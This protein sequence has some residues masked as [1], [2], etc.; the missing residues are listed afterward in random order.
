MHCIEFYDAS[1][2]DSLQW[3]Q[4]PDGL[5]AQKMLTPM[6]KR[7]SRIF[8]SNAQAQVYVLKIHDHILPITVN[9]KE[10]DNSY[11]ASNY[12]VIPFIKEWLVQKPNLKWVGKPVLWAFGKC[13]RVLKVNK[14]VFINN[15]LLSSNLYPQ[16]SP[17]FLQEVKQFLTQ[18]FPDHVLMFRN[19]NVFKEMSLMHALQKEK[20]HIMLT[21]S[22][23]VYD[24]KKKKELSS[25]ALYH[26][27]SDVRLFDKLGYKV[28]SHNDF[29]EKDIP[30]MLELYRK[31]YI[32]KHTP[33]SPAYTHEFLLSAMEE[34]FFRFIGVCKDGKLD[35]VI[36][37]IE[38]NQVLSPLFFGYETRSEHAAELYRMTMILVI[39]E[40]EKRGLIL[41]DN[42]GGSKPKKYRGMRPFP[43]YTA[44]YD[45]HLPWG[46][47]LF[48][49][50]MTGLVNKIILPLVSKFS[51]S[52]A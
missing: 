46:R 33:F 6:I 44:I 16:I 40:A 10:Y 7:G 12:Y 34:G 29:S 30:R 47:K 52:D 20:F 13:L 38:H 11:V 3:P 32:E 15:W 14:V 41:N 17:P 48:W 21:R 5:Q 2:I 36:G 42:S 18:K 35:G 37:C 23:F 49:T 26:H 50:S 4:T 19:V 9:E 8:V 22:V 31:A 24:P 1:N 51:S 27:R 39:E 43:E 45:S 25:K 28:I